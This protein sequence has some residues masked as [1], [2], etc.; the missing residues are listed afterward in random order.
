L[1]ARKYFKVSPCDNFGDVSKHSFW[2]SFSQVQCEL[3]IVAFYIEWFIQAHLLWTRRR[4][5]QI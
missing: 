1:K 2:V 3:E 4:L 5:T